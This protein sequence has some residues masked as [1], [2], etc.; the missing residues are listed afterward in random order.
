MT[1]KATLLFNAGRQGWSETW[2]REGDELTVAMKH[3]KERY[4]PLRKALLGSGAFVEGIRCSIEGEPGHS[5]LEVDPVEGF[6]LEAQPNFMRDKPWNGWLILIQAQNLHRRSFVLRGMPD[7]WIEVDAAKNKAFPSAAFKR[8]FEK[9]ANEIIDG[10][11]KMKVL[12]KDPATAPLVEITG[13]FPQQLGATR[14][15]VAGGAFQIGEY[16]RM[17]GFDMPQLRFLN[18]VHRVIKI[19]VNGLHFNIPL[20]QGADALYLGGASM[21]KQ[22]TTYVDISDATMIRAA[23]RDTGRAF[24]VPRGRR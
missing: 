12:S 4:L 22:V 11:Y 16:V 8:A 14:V 10:E 17:S 18:G 3:F 24:F 7:T 1:V 21:R 19:D 9:W 23:K 20:P 6:E 5:R 15:Q 2:Y 13:V